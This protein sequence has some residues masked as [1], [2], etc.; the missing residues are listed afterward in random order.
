[1]RKYNII[2]LPKEQWKDHILPMDYTSD[3][4][5]DV[6]IEKK[7]GAFLA[8]FVKKAA[9]QPISHTGEEY[10]FPDK[11]YQDFWEKAYAWGILEEGRLVAAIET[12]PEEWSNRLRVT[13][14]WVA[15]G[16]RRM[17][18]GHA[19]MS[20]A[21]EQ[22]RLERRRAIILETQSCNSAAISFYL[23][24][25]FSLIGFDACCYANN[26]LARKEVRMEL[27]LIFNK[28]QKLPLSAVTIRPETPADYMQTERMAQRAFWNKHQPGCDEHLLVHKLRTDSCY[29]PEISRVAEVDGK[30]VGCIM[31]SKSCL[32]N[33]N[34]NH[35][36]ITFGPLCVDP[37]YAGMGI[38]E[39]L[40]KETVKLAADAGYPGI[41]IFG[42][43]DYYPRL[44]FKTCDYFGITTADG[45]NFDAFMGLELK[46][47]AL[48]AIGGRFH[49]AKVFETLTAEETEILNQSFP[50][51]EKQQFPG[52]WK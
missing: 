16:Q 52:Q 26:D 32:S 8:S 48:S 7:E 41:V 30:I 18:M 21:K 19:L 49:E 47:D 51:L 1:M 3:F 24:E 44:G 6:S 46:K 28:P 23:K 27:G 13:E 35:D 4:Y 31:Y 34:G 2:H 20:L 43:P 38:G 33:E 25:G 10:D 40:V 50:Y 39:M 22:A 36:I 29:L 5:Y 17:G 11:L 37:D 14:L 42:E 12:C 45:K 15:E 9:P